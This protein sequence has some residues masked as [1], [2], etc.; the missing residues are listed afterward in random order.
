MKSIDDL[1]D[2]GVKKYPA[3]LDGFEEFQIFTKDDEKLYNLEL[4]KIISRSTI[5]DTMRQQG[6]DFVDCKEPIYPSFLADF[7]SLIKTG[8]FFIYSANKDSR[9]IVLVTDYYKPSNNNIIIHLRGYD[10]EIKYITP[11]NYKILEYGVDKVLNDCLHVLYFKRII[12]D[13]MEK[14]VSDVHFTNN[15]NRHNSYD[16]YIKYRILNNYVTQD[17]FITT[18]ELNNRLIQEII[19]NY[20]TAESA[21]L[22]TSYGVETSWVNIMRDGKVDLRI[23]C[24]KTAGGYTMV[25][26]IQQMSTL[27]KRIENLGF[28]ERICADLRDLSDRVTGLTLITGAPRTGKNTTMVAMINEH[29]DKQIKRIEYSSPI[30]T[31][32]PHEQLAYDS[33]VNTL[34]NYVKL[35]K[36]QDVDIAILN[37]LPD[38]RLAHPV[39][40]LVNSSIGVFTTF[41]INRLWNVA[42]KLKSYFGDDYIDL[43]TQINGVVHQKMFVKLCPHCVHDVYHRDFPKYIL[44]IMDNYEIKSF[45]ESS[46]CI[47]C[48]GTGRSSEVQPYAESLI[49]TTELKEKL[50]RCTRPHEMEIILK[51]ECYAKKVNMEVSVT[52]AIKNGIL[53][54]LD[55]EILR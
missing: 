48:H 31:I 28:N 42:L 4:Y 40:D 3:I 43:I 51:E 24:S 1:V 35:V 17:V 14:H 11:L 16:Y 6:V 10:V 29:V 26:R 32:M 9:Q 15:Q 45:K 20:T 49:F 37:E 21:D 34:L 7:F 8:G 30:E 55:L 46:G 36:K 50:V 19:S 33:D 13:A 44:E 52:D 27:G 22:E 2:Y 54:P 5:I 23:T 18:K 47:L 12:Y 39:I 41:H 25:I 53:H 38:K